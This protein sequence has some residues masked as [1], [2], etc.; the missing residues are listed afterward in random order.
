MKSFL[1]FQFNCDRLWKLWYS[2]LVIF[3]Q[4][5]LII[6]AISNYITYK[7]QAF[8]PRYGNS[9]S[10]IPLNFQLGSIILSISLLVWLIYSCMFKVGHIAND[11]TELG[12]DSDSIKKALIEISSHKGISLFGSRLITHALP[13][14]C[15]IHLI[16]ALLLALPVPLMQA[17]QIRKEAISPGYYKYNYFLFIIFVSIIKGKRDNI[18]IIIHL[19]YI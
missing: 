18:I 3:T 7:S 9:W 10:M 8:D 6:F 15:L 14:N 13:Y 11:G 5:I 19:R 2:I 17:E 1:Q 16:I 4:I 12:L